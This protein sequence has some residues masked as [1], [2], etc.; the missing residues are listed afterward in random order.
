MDKKQALLTR[1]GEIGESLKNSG[2][3]LALLGLGSVGLERERIDEYS[4]LDFFAIVKEGYK[5]EFID[6]LNWLS[7]I[8]PL[9]YAFRNTVDGYKALYQDDIFCEFAVFEPWELEKI[10]FSEGKIIWKQGYF[11]ESLC[12]P[13][14]LPTP[15]ESSVEYLVGEAITNLYVGVGRYK[16]GEKLSAARFIQNYAVDRIIELSEKIEQE[17]SA[18][19]DIF[20][21]ERRYEQRFPSIAANLPLFIQGYERSIQSAKAILFFLDTYFE[22]NSFMKDKILQLCEEE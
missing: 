19:K 2:K 22:V 13:K 16:R 8:H 1:L 9:V 18:F 3:G 7:N 14:R 6:N 15:T 20:M 17:Q 21:N 5:Q 10:P 4:D 11:N 12:I